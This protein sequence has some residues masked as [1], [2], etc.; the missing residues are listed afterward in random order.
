[1]STCWLTSGVAA[2]SAGPYTITAAHPVPDD[3]RAALTKINN[4]SR[5]RT[6]LIK[7]GTDICC[8]GERTSGGRDNG[9]FGT[10]RRVRSP[11][12]RL[13]P[14][15]DHDRGFPGALML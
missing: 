10:Y 7:V 3:F 5:V 11:E 2:A 6:S 1:M 9:H 14:D 12:T 15:F 13:G 4:A 8:Y